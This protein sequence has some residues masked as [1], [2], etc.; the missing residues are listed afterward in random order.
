M[1]APADVPAPPVPQT[2]AMTSGADG[3]THRVAEVALGEALLAG[4]GTSPALCGHTVLVT[5]LGAEPG[6]PCPRCAARTAG[7]PGS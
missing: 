5:S 6:R 2:I 1:V 4:R 3:L 7:R